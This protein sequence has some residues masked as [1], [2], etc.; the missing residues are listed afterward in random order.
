[1]KDGFG[2]P[3]RRG[4]KGEDKRNF[5]RYILL[6]FL[7]NISYVLVG[8][9]VVD[10]VRYSNIGYQGSA[11]FEA[12][13]GAFG[14]LG[15]DLSSN[16]INPAGYGRFSSS[17]V[18]TTIHYN[19]I[20]AKAKFQENNLETK[21]GN[22]KMPSLGIVLVKD[23]SRNNKG[24]L[25]SQ[26]GFS[27]NRLENFA[28]VKRYQGALYKS[29]LDEFAS[30]GQGIIPDNLPPFTTMLAWNTYAIDPDGADG[31]VANLASGDT[32][33]QRRTITTKGGVGNFSFN[34]SFNYLNKLYFGANVG[35]NSINYSDAYTHS[36]VN[37]PNSISAVDSFNYTYSLRTKGAGFNLK[38]GAI[39]LPADFL[40]LGLAFHSKT[41]Y[42]LTDNWTADM[43]TYRNDGVFNIPPDYIPVGNYKYRLQ[44]PA[45]F[46]GSVGFIIRKMAA[47]DVDL[48]FVNY[49]GNKFKSTRNFAYDPEPNN[50]AYQNQEIRDLLAPKLNF[51]I[52]GE[53]VIAK[54]YFVRL[55]F[56][57]YPQPYKKAFSGSYQA[58][59]VY[60]GGIGFRIKERLSVD[61]AYKLQ[62]NNFDYIAYEGSTAHFKQSSSL[63]VASISFRF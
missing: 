38:L 41:Y 20:N 17:V 23:N 8:Q 62:N 5:S 31:Y 24:F 42:N 13:A 12:M 46:I 11:R 6:L 56:A 48:E 39:Y 18:G 2:F 35:I 37:N 59:S 26:F 15:A 32:T 25:Y 16:Q 19:S 28:T 33:F 9:N 30:Y 10:A 14:A 50:Y 1:M 57:H 55:G 44:T 36:E 4:I 21:K 61:L 49:R 53:L 43:T 63:I 52:G 51:R 22:A 27:Y 45:K 40:R 58:T 3:L 60:S 7:T 34:Y 29:L 47:I 54:N